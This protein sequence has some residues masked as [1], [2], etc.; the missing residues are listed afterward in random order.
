MS[1]LFLLS[2]VF[3]L[4][5]SGSLTQDVVTLSFGNVIG[6]NDS[7]YQV[8][9]FY[10]IPYALPPTGRLLNIYFLIFVPKGTRR[11]APPEAWSGSYNNGSINGTYNANIMCPQPTNANSTIPCTISYF[12]GLLINIQAYMSEDCLFLNIFFSI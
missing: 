2:Y 11:Y 7:D 4:G 8:R 6:L 9:Y 5:V 12:F 1:L 3:F 10:N